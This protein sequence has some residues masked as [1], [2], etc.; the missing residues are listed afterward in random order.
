MKN[1]KCRF[2]IREKFQSLYY[3]LLSFKSSNFHKKDLK[4]V[5]VDRRAFNSILK[6]KIF[7]RQKSFPCERTLNIVLLQKSFR[8]SIIESFIRSYFYKRYLKGFLSKPSKVFEKLSKKSPLKGR[9]LKGP[10]LLESF[11]GHLFL[12]E[13][14]NVFYH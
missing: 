9:A 3:F 12:K 2:I 11:Q 10:L 8:G 7:K 4:G 5:S 14:K 6:C 13:L 1:I